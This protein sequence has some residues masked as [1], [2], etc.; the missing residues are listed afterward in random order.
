MNQIQE[1]FNKDTHNPPQNFGL[2]TNPI[3]QTNTGL[4]E[5][6]GIPISPSDLITDIPPSFSWM[7]GQWKYITK[8]KHQFTDD[9]GKNIWSS[10]VVGK[11]D[12][13]AFTPILPNWFNLPFAA[14]VWWNGTVS[15]RFTMI[16][17][18][19]VS[20]KL[21]ITYRQDAFKAYTNSDTVTL[22]EDKLYRSINKEWD[23]S[24]SSQFEFDITGSLP[25]R[26]RPTKIYKNLK[27]L[28]SGGQ[29]S[30]NELAISGYQPPWINY[31]MGRILVRPA[32][33]LNPGGLFPDEFVVIVEKSFKQ[34]NFYT[35]TDTKSTYQ[36][37]TES[38]F[39]S[40][41]DG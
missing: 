17:P 2:P 7:T 18:P 35:P 14:S 4:L 28:G 32:Q 27:G 38:P 21:I 24:Q 34:A 11:N 20:G 31:E 26:A 3:P 30:L 5:H 25:I 22:S 23:L 1:A 33:K 37:V 10:T 12:T 6:T 15:F 8:F 29:P 9:I 13:T 40:L 41:N 19:R 16:K 36:L 39:S